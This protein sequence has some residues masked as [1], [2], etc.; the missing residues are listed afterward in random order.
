[1]KNYL[2]IFSLVIVPF[3]CIMMYTNQWS[4]CFLFC[5]YDC[6]CNFPWSCM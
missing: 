6:Y 1:M 3:S 4:L 2:K 5:H